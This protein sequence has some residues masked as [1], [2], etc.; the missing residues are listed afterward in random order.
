MAQSIIYLH[1]HVSMQVLYPLYMNMYV[2]VLVHI[3]VQC[4]V[5]MLTQ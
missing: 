3:H 4:T 5:S 1:E 2:H